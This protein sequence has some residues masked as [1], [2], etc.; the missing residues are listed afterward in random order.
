MPPTDPPKA[1]LDALDFETLPKPTRG[2]TIGAEWWVAR[3]H[4]R[5]RKRES[6][7]SLV[8][9]MAMLGVTGGVA[10]LNCVLAV[11]TGLEDELRDKILGAN[12]HLVIF[13]TAQGIVDAPELLKKIDAVEGVAAAA[14]FVYQEMMIRSPMGVSGIVLKGIDPERTGDVTHVRD[15]L[16]LGYEGALKAPEARQSVMEAM[17]GSE[18]KALD[19]S[20]EPY[21]TQLEPALPGIIIGDELAENLIYVRPGDKVQIIDPGAGGSG[22]MGAPTPAAKSLRVAGVFNSGHYE[23]DT[24]WVYAD[25]KVLQDFLKMG[26]RYSGIEIR[27][28]D[29]DEVEHVTERVVEALGPEYYGRHWKEL[30]EKLF[31]ALKTEKRVMGLI[32]FMVVVNA[33]LLIVTTLLM[34]MLTK[35]REIA[36]LKAMGASDGSIQ[37]IFLMQGALIGGVGTVVGTVLG[38][39]G[40]AFIDWYG[41]ELETDVYYL[42]TLPVVVDPAT[43]ATIGVAAFVTCCVCSFYPARRAASLD[44]VE[45]LRYE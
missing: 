8:T 16:I 25:N 36:I 34:M 42:D 45:A 26:D 37:R 33:A 17:A 20:G 19:L 44:P 9:F 11:M 14:P 30:N 43:V 31:R 32:L 38:L 27:V 15:D 35:S 6:S 39:A 29:P 40:C 23:Y 22:P 13:H 5:S 3:G 1:D 10:L 24:K 18:F 41:W 4:L 7:V 12:T 2:S 28:D 21:E